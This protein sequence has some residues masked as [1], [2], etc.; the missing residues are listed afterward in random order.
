MRCNHPLFLVP[1][2]FHYPKRKP[3]PIPHFTLPWPV[4]WL[5]I[6]PFWRFQRNGIIHVAFMAWPLSFSIKFSRCI[7][8]VAVLPSSL[9][10]NN[11]P[12]YKWTPNAR[13]CLFILPL[14]GPRVVFTSWLLQIV[15]RGCK[16]LILLCRHL[17]MELL[18]HMV[19]LCLTFWGINNLLGPHFTI[20]FGVQ[21]ANMSSTQPSETVLAFCP[22]MRRMKRS[23]DLLDLL[24]FSITRR[25]NYYALNIAW[26][27][28]S[29]EYP[30]SRP[31]SP[32]F[33]KNN[34]EIGI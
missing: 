5:W 26:I 13:F 10:Q 34:K 25:L 22:G 33:L 19:F 12:L 14:N 15:L 17:E 20:I 21:S 23:R 24:F 29:H 7:H 2:H 9:W 32:Y 6:Y 30:E 4:F 16:F 18:C 8:V 11:I 3:F 31:H 1:K 28:Q 27:V